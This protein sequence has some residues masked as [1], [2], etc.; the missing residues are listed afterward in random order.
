[1]NDNTHLK[2]QL[3][4][5]ADVEN[6]VYTFTR[7]IQEEA[8]RS[9]P[10]A[11]LGNGPTNNTPLHIRALV[12][13]ERR[14]R[15]RWQRSDNPL[16]KREYNR[17]TD[18]PGSSKRPYRTYETQR[19]KHISLDFPKETTPSGKP[20]SS[21]SDQYLMSPAPTRRWHLEHI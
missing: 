12:T 16:D 4:Q 13:E 7:L 8:R 18:S 2:I 17:T 11:T 20:P 19:S 10:L 14:A 6:A 21:L 1:M 5:P 3:K 15:S 9:T